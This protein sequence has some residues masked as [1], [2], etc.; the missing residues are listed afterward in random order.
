MNRLRMLRARRSARANRNKSISP[1]TGQ[2]LPV[3]VF[4]WQLSRYLLAETILEPVDGGDS[5]LRRHTFG[6]N[7]NDLPALFKDQLA[8]VIEHVVNFR[9]R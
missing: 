7:N 5:R 6:G 3:V 8:E 4:V 9:V 1:A 2:V